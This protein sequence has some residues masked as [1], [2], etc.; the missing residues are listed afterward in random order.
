MATIKRFEDIEAWQTA[1]LMTGTIYGLTKEKPWSVDFG[2]R[3]QIRRAAVSVM[4]NIAE[5]F[6]SDE[7]A[8]FIRYLGYAKA[9]AG[10][11]RAQLYVALDSGYIDHQTF[12]RVSA[13]A[14]QCSRQIHGFISY[15]RAYRV[16]HRI[17]EDGW[18]Y[19]LTEQSTS[20]NG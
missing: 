4:S 15:L 20:E 3:D 14:V 6:E 1:R 7:A 16:D 18:A 19:D 13:L 2:L 8:Q 5:G 12:D 10:E 17:S 9:S 11:V